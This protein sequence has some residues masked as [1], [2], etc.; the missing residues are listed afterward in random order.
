MTRRPERSRGVH[1][2]KL[3]QHPIKN[4]LDRRL[5][6]YRFLDAVRIA[7]VPPDRHVGCGLFRLSSTRLSCRA[8]IRILVFPQSPQSSKTHPVCDEFPSKFPYGIASPICFRQVDE[9]RARPAIV[10]TTLGMR[11][12]GQAVSPGFAIAVL[13]D[14][15]PVASAGA[16]SH[17]LLRMEPQILRLAHETFIHYFCRGIR[18]GPDCSANRSIQQGNRGKFH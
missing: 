3:G 5:L 13:K 18:G 11:S 15:S 7:P 1:R 10:P 4:S 8:S 16:R 9:M 2:A 17:L 12:Y 6:G 14:F